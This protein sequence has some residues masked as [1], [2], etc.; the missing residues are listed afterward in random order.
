MLDKAAHD[1][2]LKV[3]EIRSRCM[4]MGESNV[5]IQAFPVETIESA[6]KKSPIEVL[7]KRGTSNASKFVHE[8]FNEWIEDC[9]FT[10]LL[11]LPYD[12]NL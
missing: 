9:G 8:M 5:D 10:E 12:K 1:C 2:V 3:E 11:Q 7:A 6:K 4:E